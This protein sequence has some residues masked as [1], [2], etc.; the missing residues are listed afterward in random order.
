MGRDEVGERRGGGR[1]RRLRMTKATRDRIRGRRQT[2]VSDAQ[3]E[4]NGR[5]G[6]EGERLEPRTKEGGMEGEQRGQG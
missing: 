6:E 2:G 4:P 5:G 1:M 3:N